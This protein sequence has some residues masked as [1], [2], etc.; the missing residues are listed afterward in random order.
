MIDIAITATLRP[1]LL[2]R[3]LRSFYDK[4]FNEYCYDIKNDNLHIVINVDPVGNNKKISKKISQKNILKVCE[5]FSNNITY[6]FAP[7]ASFPKAV[8]WVWSNCKHDYVFHLEDDWELNR[9]IRLKRLIKYLIK[10]EVVAIKLYKKTYPKNEPYVMFDSEYKYDG[11]ELFI[12]RD[13]GTQFGLNPTLIKRSYLTEALPLMVDD[14]NPE[15][16]F[17][18]RNPNMK[19][20]VLKYK[21][22]IFGIPGDSAL[23]TDIGTSW[24]EKRNI[25]KPKGTSFLTWI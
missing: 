5:E 4:C 21:Y 23:V 18:H 7:E 25:R 20:F 22:G 3:T 24:R 16:Q 14:L 1:E 6:N 13:S 12:A 2:Y 19:E 17:R 10:T 9:Y 15:K 8:K 11:D